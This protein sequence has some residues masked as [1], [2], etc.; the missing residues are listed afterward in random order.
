MCD[1]TNSRDFIEFKVSQT[2]Y[3]VIGE[4]KF[5][6]DRTLFA[7]NDRYAWHG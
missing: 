6:V 5:N 3:G 4:Q 1:A 7:L 2:D